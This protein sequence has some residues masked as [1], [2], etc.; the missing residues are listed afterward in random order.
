MLLS[1]FI[2]SS[3]L[4]LQGLYPPEEASGIV[5]LLLLKRFSIRSYDHILDPKAELTSQRLELLQD[6]LKRLLRAEP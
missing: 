1:E 3:C 5:S 4:A 2:R 6:D